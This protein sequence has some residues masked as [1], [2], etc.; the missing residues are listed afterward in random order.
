MSLATLSSL[1]RDGRTPSLP[2]TMAGSHTPSPTPTAHPEWQEMLQWQ[3]TWRAKFRR[4]LAF[5][6]DTPSL[7][8]HNNNL[9]RVSQARIAALERKV[10]K[11]GGTVL[12]AL[13]SNVTDNLVVVSAKPGNA[14][15]G[16]NAPPR[17]W[18]LDKLARFFQNYERDLR[19][20]ATDTAGTA[21]T[22]R[23][24]PG[25]HTLTGT[26]HVYLYDTRQRCRPLVARSWDVALLNRA[27]KERLPYPVL[28]RTAVYGRCPFARTHE[29][30]R[31]DSE[32]LRR[33]YARDCANERYALKL[34]ALYRRAA[35][36]ASG[37]VHAALELQPHGQAARLYAYFRVGGARS[38]QGAY[39]ALQRGALQR[40]HTA[41]DVAFNSF[42]ERGGPAGVPLD[43]R[44]DTHRDSPSSG[45]NDSLS[46]NDTVATLTLS[47]LEETH[48][49]RTS[50]R[51]LS[52]GASRFSSQQ[53]SAAV[54]EG[55]PPSAAEKQT[56][57]GEVVCARYCENCHRNYAGT[58]RQHACSAEHAERAGVLDFARV[59][60]LIAAVGGAL[61]P[62]RAG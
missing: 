33:R 54:N 44:L 40:A 41:M 19:G 59:D 28:Q 43:F 38:S 3:A 24:A 56:P 23:A 36:P 48:E 58:V 17:T 1:V 10:R 35:R 29:D 11:H 26:P 31:G 53:D 7:V 46:S 45:D 2:R 61:S 27:R 5:Y 22:P 32:R 49:P 42:S 37:P 62:A 25:V 51:A 60:A 21:E 15:A 14:P 9:R 30:P 50:L 12:P 8:Q 39:A 16:G 13:P 52:L 57:V 6:F 47:E 55:V 34:R 20:Y 4:G 18:D